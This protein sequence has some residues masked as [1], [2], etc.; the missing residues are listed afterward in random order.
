MSIACQTRNG[1]G[2]PDREEWYLS[3]FDQ[4]GFPAE[5]IDG[6]QQRAYGLRFFSYD[7]Q[8]GHCISQCK[9]KIFPE[10]D[11]PHPLARVRNICFG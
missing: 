4:V 2:C 6:D 8:A 7:Y 9:S 1:R 3:G 11:I 10:T 5:G